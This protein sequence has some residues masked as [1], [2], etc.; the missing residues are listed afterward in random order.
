MC[1]MGSLEVPPPPLAL[2]LT[3]HAVLVQA[4][5]GLLAPGFNGVPQDEQVPFGFAHQLDKDCALAS[6]LAAKAAHDLL[7]DLAQL[8]GLLTHGLGWRGALAHDDLDEA[9]DF[10]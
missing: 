9:Q 10:F 6:A 8:P 2:G 1:G 5:S 3:P 7:Q 4:L